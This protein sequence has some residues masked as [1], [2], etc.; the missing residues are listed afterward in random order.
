MATST[1]QSLQVK[2]LFKLIY[3]Q[4][5]KR[6]VSQNLECCCIATRMLYIIWLFEC[7]TPTRTSNGADPTFLHPAHISEFSISVPR[8]PKWR[9]NRVLILWATIL[10]A[11]RR[12]SRPR[13]KQLSMSGRT[14]GWDLLKPPIDFPK[15]FFTCCCWPASLDS[16]IYSHISSGWILNICFLYIGTFIQYS[17]LLYITVVGMQIWIHSIKKLNSDV[18]N[19]DGLQR[20]NV[21][22][23]DML[24]TAFPIELPCSDRCLTPLKKKQENNLFEDC[25]LH[26][27]IVN[28]FCIFAMVRFHVGQLPLL[29][30]RGLNRWVHI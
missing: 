23:F 27:R 8:Q 12:C 13:I 7:R 10:R 1:M 20:T 5:G 4:K 29:W 3:I 6:A 9:S 25:I 2:F 16:Y 18:W 28:S 19:R 24:T 22:G 15:A 21:L 11:S 26:P 30:N 14:R 17:I